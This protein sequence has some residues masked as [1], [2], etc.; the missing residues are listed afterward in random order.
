MALGAVV[1]HWFLFLG[2]GL[3]M[4]E[5]GGYLYCR[6]VMPDPDFFSSGFPRFPVP[7]LFTL[8]GLIVLLVL[9]TADRWYFHRSFRVACYPLILFA[10]TQLLLMY[11]SVVWAI[12]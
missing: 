1:L 12:Y 11:L 3:A 2:W 6:L 7:Y 9:G 8:A 5:A 4:N 10:L